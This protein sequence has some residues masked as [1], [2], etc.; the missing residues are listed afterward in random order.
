MPSIVILLSYYW[1]ITFSILG[2][3]IFFYK[4]FIK[5]GNITIGYLGIYGIFFL[6]IISYLSHFFLPHGE[7]FN[8]LIVIFGLFYFYLNKKNFFLKKD[9]KYFIIIFFVL[10]IFILAA[11][12]HDDFPYYHFPYTHI[13]TELSNVIGLGNFNHGFRTPSSIFYLSS[14]FNLPFSDLF[15]LNL[16]PV[17]FL[18]FGNLILLN[19][20]KDNLRASD[21]GPILYLSLMCFI[22]INIFFYRMAEHGTDRSAMILIIILIIEILHLSNTQN[23]L[24]ETHFLKLIILITMVISLKSFYALYMTLFIPPLL[25]FTKNKMSFIYFFKNKTLYMCI[26]M[27]FLVLITNFFNSG[28]LIYPVKFLCFDNFSWSI[29]LSEVELMNNWYQ[30]WSKAGASPNFRV[31]N[32]EIYIQN[33]NWVSNWVNEYFFNK[34]SDF[35]LGLAFLISIVFI[36]FYSKI[37]K[38]KKNFKFYLLYLILVFLTLEWFYI[39]PSLRYGG[40]HLIALLLFIPTSVFISKFLINKSKLEIKVYFLIALT[41][42]VFSTRNIMRIN[43]EYNLYNYNILTNSFYRAEE[44]NFGV[45]DKINNIKICLDDLKN[46]KCKKEYIQLKKLNG[47]KIYYRKK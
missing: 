11:K 25:L 22:F 13:L 37:N 36:T 46:D 3:G 16:S 39:H 1:L 15:L 34:V 40:Y 31:E 12:N 30:Q 20:I 9:L 5:D 26:S 33:F 29:P 28:C 38:K 19:K 23:K 17:F 47:Y 2:Y 27:M 10:I 6:S 8:S 35:L 18:G 41:F 14:F 7:V 45:F 4:N 42:L 21:S 44:Q 32:P 43:K 24:N